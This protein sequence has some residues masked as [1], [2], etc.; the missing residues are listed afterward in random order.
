MLS[1]APLATSFPSVKPKMM[2]KLELNEWQR[3]MMLKLL[4]G[5]FGEY[6]NSSRYKK[7]AGCSADTANRDLISLTE[8]GLIERTG[9][10]KAP[11]IH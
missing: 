3:M 1:S 4:D 5:G 9:K 11:R 6:L 2:E 7:S 8:L 10:G